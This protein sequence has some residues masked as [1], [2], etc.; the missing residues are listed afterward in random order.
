MRTPN[1]WLPFAL[2]GGMLVATGCSEP[3]SLSCPPGNGDV[4]VVDNAFE[5]RWSGEETTPRLMEEWRLDLP[6]GV[7][8]RPEAASI[9]DSGTLIIAELQTGMVIEFDPG[10]DHAPSEAPLPARLVASLTDA[11]LDARLPLP[12]VRLLSSGSFLVVL[13]PRLIPEGADQRRVSFVVRVAPDGSFTDTLYAASVTVLNDHGFVEWPRPGTTTPLI[14]AG[15]GGAVALAGATSDYRID[16]LRSDF[17]DSLVVCRH[18]PALPLTESEAGEIELPGSPA[19]LAWLLD[20]SKK[21]KS[22][23]PFGR[24]FLGQEGRLWVQRERPDPQRGYAQPVGAAYDL[25][26]AGGAYLGEVRAPG[27]IVLI[28]EAADFV[29]GIEVSD[30]GPLSLVAFALR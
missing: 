29:Y 15:P 12:P 1:G 17:T 2:L 4:I 8:L 25:F 13:P 19:R 22:P 5:G 6:E 3:A 20:V 30:E 27:R 9:S 23:L 18:A 14:A 11:I 10:A 16:V 7:G 21:V 28:G 26:A 24:I